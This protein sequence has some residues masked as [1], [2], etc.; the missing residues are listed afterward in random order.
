MT[1]LLN[2]PGTSLTLT[3]SAIPHWFED[4]NRAAEVNEPEDEAAPE[5]TYT[6][7]EMAAARLEAWNDG[8]VAASR[9]QAATHA[10]ANDRLYREMLSQAEQLDQKL[11]NAAERNATLIAR[12]LA[13]NVAAV[14]PDLSATVMADRTSRVAA[15]LRSALRSQTR[16]ELR[17]GN[18][19]VTMCETMQDLCQQIAQRNLADHPPDDVTITWEHGEARIDLEQTWQRIRAAILPL[20]DNADQT[21]NPGQRECLSH[22]G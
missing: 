13:R 22:V 21:V 5:Q 15:L 3:T 16:I 18:E 4:F 6:A 10:N 17:I 2:E 7:A 1:K 14:L 12:W 19:P 8:F 9:G 20:A 11:D